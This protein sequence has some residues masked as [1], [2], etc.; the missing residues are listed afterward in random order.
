MMKTKSELKPG[1]TPRPGSKTESAILA[2][3]DGP[4]PTAQLAAIME[5]PTASVG[6]G[7]G[8]ALKG[9]LVMRVV[10]EAE[11]MHFALTSLGLPEGFSA[12]KP[13]DSWPAA[14]G[15][16]ALAG[17]RADPG[18]PF[19]LVAKK[20][21]PA[22][23]GGV[24]IDAAAQQ[25]REEPAQVRMAPPTAFAKPPAT[26]ARPVA[27]PLVDI[28]VKISDAAVPGTANEIADDFVAAVF[29]TGELM[30]RVGKDEVRLTPVHQRKLEQFV[31]R[32]EESQP[33]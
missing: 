8:S 10:D 20:A 33:C 31:S 25:Q 22:L 16:T 28:A 4:V 30:I 27:A 3:N 14:A 5:C 23:F 29:S 12:W 2:M 19:G 6:A 32:F 7:L 11:N 9:G 17:S 13:K 26:P 1:Y 24:D 15:A 21:T 18:D